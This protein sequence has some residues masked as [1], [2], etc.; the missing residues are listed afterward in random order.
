MRQMAHRAKCKLCGKRRTLRRSHL[1]PAALYKMMREPGSK[2]SNPI[3]ISRATSVSTSKQIWAHLLCEE[4]EHRF[5]IGGENYVMTQVYG[6]IRFPL[7]DRLRVALP[8]QEM[9]GLALY[10]GP[11]IGVNTRRLAYFALSVFWRA[12]VHR[13]RAPHGGEV[14][15]SLGAHEEP[16]R[17]F[18]LGHGG[19]PADLIVI[20]TACTDAASQ[21]SCFTPCV[22]RG[23]AHEGFG[24]L[25]RGIHFRLFVGADLPAQLR[26]V[27]CFTSP[28]QVILRGSCHRISMHA[29]ANLQQ[30]SKPS[31]RLQKRA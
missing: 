3:V 26:R 13:W 21:G 14:W 24:M 16:V 28:R 17:R 25:V 12:S 29:F 2:V 1:L 5:N 20:V 31:R 15:Y 22:V 23:G 18:L 4:C 10:S 11:A 27:C 7:L 6:N 8:F 19:F 30:T 9:P